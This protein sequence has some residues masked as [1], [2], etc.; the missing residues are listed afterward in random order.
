MTAAHQRLRELDH[1]IANIADDADARDITKK[2]ERI[3]AEHCF[4]LGDENP[5]RPRFQRGI[6]AKTWWQPGG[7]EWVRSLLRG[8]DTMLSVPP[9][10]L[11]VLDA[12]RIAVKLRSLVCPLGDPA[13]GRETMSWSL[14]AEEIWKARVE[15]N[16]QKD[17]CDQEAV[18]LGIEATYAEWRSCIEMHRTRRATLPLGRLRALTHGWVLLRGKRDAKHRCV[19][20]HIV[21]LATGAAY[22]AQDCA[23]RG[24]DPASKSERAGRVALDA[25]REAAWM[26]L[27]ADQVESTLQPDL[28]LKRIPSSVKRTHIDPESDFLTIKLDDPN[29]TPM[30]WQIVGGGT[31]L[32]SGQLPWPRS[33]RAGED[34]AMHLWRVAE[35][36]FEEGCVPEPLPSWLPAGSKLTQT[37]L[38]ELRALGRN[39]CRPAS[40]AAPPPPHDD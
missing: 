17:E 25:S 23:E 19:E 30:Q 12:S 32:A 36:S 1:D 13:C 27:L 33:S 31:L 8:Y 26:T 2:L 37:R 3:L 10:V 22:F 18:R 11:P 20:T 39:A 4:A 7:K 16:F 35:A 9:D 15:L 6:Q 34:Y 28:D 29:Y 5:R 40:C 38:D 24:R 14:R 21:S